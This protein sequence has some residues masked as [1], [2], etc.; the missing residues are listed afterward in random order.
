MVG[1]ISEYLCTSRQTCI[2]D[3]SLFLL[4]VQRSLFTG[5]FAAQ[6]Y[7]FCDYN[8]YS[9]YTKYWLIPYRHYFDEHSQEICP[10]VCPAESNEIGTGKWK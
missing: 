9:E 7:D 6:F 4:N 2:K 5:D 1:S 3:L 8:E 10:Y